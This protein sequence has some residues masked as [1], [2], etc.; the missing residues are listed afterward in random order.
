MLTACT[1]FSP[2]SHALPTVSLT[3]VWMSMPFLV[4]AFC[5]PTHPHRCLR[6]RPTPPNASNASGGKR[7]SASVAEGEDA[8][9]KKGTCQQ[10]R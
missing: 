1:Y 4:H 2:S 6:L 10:G 5:S 9:Q 7:S 8:A 3:T